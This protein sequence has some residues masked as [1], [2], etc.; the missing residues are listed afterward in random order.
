[1]YD[2]CGSFCIIFSIMNVII[3]EVLQQLDSSLST[4]FDYSDVSNSLDFLLRKSFN[5]KEIVH[6]TILLLWL[7]FMV[8]DYQSNEKNIVKI[9]Q[10]IMV[11]LLIVKIPW[12]IWWIR[13]IN[14]FFNLKYL[15]TFFYS[16]I[17]YFKIVNQVI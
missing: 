2:I 8:Y 5:G 13:L 16:L 17:T 7:V 6:K 10:N 1:M 4:E 9:W 12:F 15:F 11:K 14:Q 3:D